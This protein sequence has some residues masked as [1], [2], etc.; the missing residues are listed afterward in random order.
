MKVIKHKIKLFYCAAALF[1]LIQTVAYSQGTDIRSGKQKHFFFGFTVSPATSNTLLSG[2]QAISGV[3]SEKKTSIFGGLEIGYFFSRIFGLSTGFRYSTLSNNFSLG[4]YSDSYKTMDSD[5]PPEQYE[6]RIKGSNIL[7]KPNISFLSVPLA[8]NLHIPFSKSFGLYIQPGIYYSIPMQKN[9]TSRGTFSYS[10]YYSAYNVLIENVTYEG[11]QSN[12]DNRVTGSLKLKSS[13]LQL[14]TS[15]GFQINAGS[16]LQ[17]LLG[18]FY[19]KMLS[20][21]SGNPTGSSSSLSTGPGQMKSL[22][23]VSTQTKASNM[24]LQLTLRLLL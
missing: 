14:F 11:F 17:I 16:T 3:V 21:I 18:G 20:D 13:Y 10:G 7:E 4:S 2:S 8:L 23:Q 22:L 1:L 15:A 9:F 6:R 5:L 24:G 19:D 12:V